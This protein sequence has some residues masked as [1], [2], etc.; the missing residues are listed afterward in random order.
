M[1]TKLNSQVSFQYNEN[2]SPRL[3]H[4]M[5]EA[6]HHVLYT[7][8]RSQYL[9]KEYNEN[10][11]TESQ[12]IQTASIESWKWWKTLLIDVDVAISGLCL[13]WVVM[14]FLPD[15]KSEKQEEV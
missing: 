5:K 6:V 14:A 1:N 4:Q 11:D 13:L 12:V 3:Q 10:P 2:G 9:N 15:K 7:W 8:L